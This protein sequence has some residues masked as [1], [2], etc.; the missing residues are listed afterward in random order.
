MLS[1]TTS[2]FEL[3]NSQPGDSPVQQNVSTTYS[4]IVPSVSV[5]PSP[6]QGQMQQGQMQQGQ[7]QQGQMQ[8]GQIQQGQM[9][10]GQMQQ[11]QGQQTSLDMNTI[12]QIVNGLQQASLTGSTQLPSRDIPQTQHQDAWV[13]PNYVPPAPAGY[14]PE[15]NSPPVDYQKIQQQRQ[16]RTNGL[17]EM[18]QELQ[19]PLLLA[20]LYFIFQLPLFRQLLFKNAPGLFF[21]DGNPNLYGYV[22][23]ST[24]FGGVFYILQKS[25]KTINTF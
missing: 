23:M 18:Y 17:E 21:K 20:L 6:S 2:L 9:Q 4:P 10:Q 12:N 14:I 16:T 7:M 11:G 1:D 19:I 5:S 24:V 22:F 13:Q 8:Q 15:Y 25:L 3:P